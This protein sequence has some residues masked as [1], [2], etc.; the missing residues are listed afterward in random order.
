MTWPLA[1]EAPHNE[2]RKPETMTLKIAICPMRC[3]NKQGWAGHP[4]YW[5]GRR[6]P[7]S[8]RDSRATVSRMQTPQKLG[9]TGLE[10]LVFPLYVGFTF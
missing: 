6:V 3:N 10:F 4:H 1:A 8:V 9:L 7:A 2:V 5:M